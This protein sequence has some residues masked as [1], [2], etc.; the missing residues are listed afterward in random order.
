MFVIIANI[1][2]II[3]YLFI[4][5]NIIVNKYNLQIVYILLVS[6]V[7]QVFDKPFYLQ[8]TMADIIGIAFIFFRYN[9]YKQFLKS[10]N[11][12]NFSIL[13]F[14]PILIGFLDTIF[15]F[16]FTSFDITKRFTVYIFAILRFIG[17]FGSILFISFNFYSGRINLYNIKKTIIFSILISSLT[18]YIV[19]LNFSSPYFYFKGASYT[20]DTADYLFQYRLSG[21]CYEP[22]LLGYFSALNFFLVD[23]IFIN[24]KYTIFIKIFS[25]ITLALTISMSGITFFLFLMFFYYIINIKI[26][27]LIK[28]F[29]FL[30]ILLILIYFIFNDYVNSFITQFMFNFDKR[31]ALDN[32]PRHFNYFPDLF[33]HFEL[34]DLPVLNYFDHNIT[35]IFY[36]FGYGLGRIF[37]APYSWIADITGQSLGI[38]GTST[39]C[40]PMVGIVYFLSIGGVF[41]LLFWLI[42]F[43]INLF[44]FKK[45]YKVF[46]KKDNI[47]IFLIFTSTIFL[48]FQIPQSS[49]IILYYFIVFIFFNLPYK[50][51]NETILHKF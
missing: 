39:C 22:R 14:T 19:F 30:S 34:H 37:M 2:L 24:K 18:A 17:I 23:S 43:F 1:L 47:F 49:I 11:I 50:Y 6:T 45:M 13:L 3:L 25:L 10:K 4:I 51:N 46:S 28:T 21:L 40:E 42:F 33:T 7:I 9:G 12:F 29:S 26:I 35:H 36:G 44:K 32:N 48:L 16:D 15:P 38:I 27:K 31:V 8:I 41:F 5:Y 20:P